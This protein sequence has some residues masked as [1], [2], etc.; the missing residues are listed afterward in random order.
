MFKTFNLYDVGTILKW[1]EQLA[2]AR[3]NLVSTSLRSDQIELTQ[4]RELCSISVECL[5]LDFVVS[6]TPNAWDTS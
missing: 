2:E 5:K 1:Q 4:L 3:K 6:S